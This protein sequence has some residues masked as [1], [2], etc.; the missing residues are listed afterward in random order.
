MALDYV[1]G[2]FNIFTDLLIF[3]IPTRVVLNLQINNER[4]L[5]VIAAFATVCEEPLLL[6]RTI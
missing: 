2:V 1:I 5:V 3:L 6:Q 4:R